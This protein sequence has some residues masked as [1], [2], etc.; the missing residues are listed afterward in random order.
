MKLSARRASDLLLPLA[1]FV[2]IATVLARADWHGRS[3]LVEQLE[4]RPSAVLPP[5]PRSLSALYHYPAEFSRFFDDHYGLRGLAVDIRARVW[6]WLLGDTFAPDVTVGK[7]RWL[8]FIG[9]GELRDALHADPLSAKAVRDWAEG[10]EARRHWLAARGIRYLFVLAPDKRAIYPEKLPAFRPGPGPTRRDQIDA[11]LAGASDFLD[12]TD[13]LRG[14]KDQGQLY[15]R[16]DTHWN[17]HGAYDAYRALAER[18]GLPP[19]P[20]DLGDGFEPA[21]R[22]GDLGRLAGLTL[23][24]HD[25]R[26]RAPCARAAPITAAPA[27]FSN[28]FD[29]SEPAYE[30]PSTTCAGGTG[31]LLM[32]HDSFGGMWAPWLSTQFAR[33]A[34]VWRPPSFDEMKRMVEI[35][36]P[37]VVIE[38]RLERFLVWPLRP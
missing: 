37:S 4:Q 22:L 12:L 5:A 2:G 21:N 7:D 34:Y 24:E 18:L 36:H 6:F 28:P 32:F 26:P 9:N 14:D 3:R 33:A 8:F 16:W 17:W 23:P 31:R 27:M 1:F 13:T 11:R 35:E 30:V 25:R 10:I 38:E 29:E 20:E 19:E 15:Y